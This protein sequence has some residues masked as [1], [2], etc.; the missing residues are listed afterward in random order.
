MTTSNSSHDLYP[1][2]AIPGVRAASQ[3]RSRALREKFVMAGR[4]MLLTVRLRD[5]SIPS[6]SEAAG[7]SIGGFYSRFESKEALFEFMR[8]RMLNDHSKLFVQNL[9]AEHHINESRQELCVAF[10][11]T[12][13]KVYG[14]PWRGILRESYASI[15]EADTNWSPMRH[16]G[17]LLR[18]TMAE[19]F[20]PHMPSSKS[21]TKRLAFGMQMIFSCLNNE[22]I[23]PNLSFS[24]SDPEFRTYLIETLDSIISRAE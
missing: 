14:G 21:N 16:R 2:D 20:E 23:N 4:D 10:V 17:N 13:L 24:I 9:D 3:K 22:L 1:L 5:I 11:D 6:L 7:S 8:A 12:M 19:L 15:A 18:F